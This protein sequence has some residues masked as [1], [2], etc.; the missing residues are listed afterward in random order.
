MTTP[1]KDGSRSA[2]QKLRLRPVV[3][4]DR[5]TIWEWA[6]DPIARS[7]SFSGEP[8][9]WADH[10]KWFE[11]RL[12]DPECHML[13][14][15]EERAE[16]IGHIRIENAHG[17]EAVI[18]VVVA[19]EHRGRGLGVALIRE[20]TRRLLSDSG[21]ATAHAFIKPDNEA[22]LRAFQRAGYR[23]RGSATVQG[24]E[25]DHWL[26]EEASRSP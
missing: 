23:R 26:Y 20:G 14:A 1:A 9:P 7:V 13:I 4:A 3:L 2:R 19:P 25:A 11:A 15:E 6:N 8:I 17:F 12:G 10:V 22:S 5:K 16:P 21:R 24:H 18:S